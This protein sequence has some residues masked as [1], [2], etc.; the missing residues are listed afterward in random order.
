MDTMPAFFVIAGAN[1][2]PDMQE[3]YNQMCARFKTDLKYYEKVLGRAEHRYKSFSSVVKRITGRN[4]I[5]G[6]GEFYAS[7]SSSSSSENSDN[8]EEAGDS[9]SAFSLDNDVERE[10]KEDEIFDF[11][12]I[13]LDEITGAADTNIHDRPSFDINILNFVEDGQRE[14]PHEGELTNIVEANL[15]D[16]INK[17]DLSINKTTVNS[18]II[19]QQVAE[20]IFDI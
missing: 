2:E 10:E 11:H 5:I 4:Q 13:N 9:S 20:G 7:S 18:D 3:L 17:D 14:D 12:D 8:E 1:D 6:Y 15:Y 19:T 16:I